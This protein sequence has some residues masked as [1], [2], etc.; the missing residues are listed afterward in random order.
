MGVSD[1]QPLLQRLVLKSNEIWTYTFDNLV[2][3]AVRNDAV[4]KAQGR[5]VVLIFDSE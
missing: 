1:T 3:P 4:C 5:V 2:R